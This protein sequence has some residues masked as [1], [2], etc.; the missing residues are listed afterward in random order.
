MRLVCKTLIGLVL[1]FPLANRAVATITYTETDSVGSCDADGGSTDRSK[2]ASIGGT[3]G[4]TEI[5][6]AAGSTDTQPY[7]YFTVYPAATV[8]W[9]S[10]TITIRFN[11][12]T[13]EMNA[14]MAS[15]SVYRYNSSCISQETLLNDTS[16][17]VDLSTTGVKTYS[18]TISAATS[19]ASDDVLVIEYRPSSTSHSATIGITPS[20]DI[21]TPFTTAGG[22]R[23]FMFIGWLPMLPSLLAGCWYRGGGN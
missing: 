9:N 12:T 5:T 4:S 7:G 17:G 10:G 13:S 2:Q 20:E 21:D 19:P 18:N 11:V 14:S 8:N 3:A 16:P 22:V 1:L 6:F 23:R 15:L